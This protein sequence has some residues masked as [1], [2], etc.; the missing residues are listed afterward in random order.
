[1]TEPWDEPSV[2]VPVDPDTGLLVEGEPV[3]VPT[4]QNANDDTEDRR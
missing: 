3:P 1:M 2:Q 4:A